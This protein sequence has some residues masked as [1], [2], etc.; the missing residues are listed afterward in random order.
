MKRNTI[1]CTAIASLTL[2]AGAALL[3]AGPLDPPNGPVSPTYKTLAEV[4]P[5]IAVNA[6]NTPGD[7][8]SVFRITQSGS[9]YLTANVLGE[10]GKHGIQIAASNV[11]LDL[12]GFA[13]RGAAGSLDGINVAT[14]RGVGIT[15]R[16]GT[17]SNWG[18]CG[19]ECEYNAGNPPQV[20]LHDLHADGNA[21]EGFRLE[22]D[23]VVTACF[24][25]ENGGD[26]FNAVAN[27]TFA[28]CM[29]KFNGGT[30][31]DSGS[32]S[33]VNGCIAAAN[34]GNGFALALQ[35]TLADSIAE[36]NAI[37]I[38]AQAS[39]IRDCVVSSSDSHGASVFGACTIAD[40][41]FYR[42]GGNGVD[43]NGGT[44]IKNCTATENDGSGFSIGTTSS[45]QGC[46][47]RD[48]GSHG[49]K[50]TNAAIILQNQCYNNGQGL[51]A[52]AGI[53]VDGSDN[54]VE[55]NNC[56]SQD[57]GIDVNAGGN[58]IIRNTCSGNTTNWTLTSGNS[59]APIVA[60]S[61]NLFGVSGDTYAGS[62]GS[63]DPN[64]NFTY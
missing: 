1:T 40:S 7:A 16:N 13:L 37:G 27:T 22:R 10:S 15:I 36:G 24:A 61:T 35:S 47:A 43:L 30:G 45:I 28:L 49:I 3:L 20:A 12:A 29:A 4:E 60:A 53:S 41:T 59:I 62:L 21:T 46:T 39:V 58:I 2:L 18:D 55:G 50:A 32:G 25:L 17:I 11:T 8:D 23:N 44:N 9:Y 5:R 51:L 26:G 38:T 57:L 64:A 52:G 33:V 56:S 14:S 63:T 19:L 34:A 48:N 31:L 42:N 6:T 54:R